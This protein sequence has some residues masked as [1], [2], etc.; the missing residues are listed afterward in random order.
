M[1]KYCM[2]TTSDVP[3]QIQIQELDKVVSPESPMASQV[4]NESA[5]KLKLTHILSTGEKQQPLELFEDKLE[6]DL[7]FLESM[8][9]S[10][11]LSQTLGM[12]G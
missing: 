12:H 3:F 1:T 5:K 8:S 2:S 10:I 4:T 11:V 7:I 9:H 6:E